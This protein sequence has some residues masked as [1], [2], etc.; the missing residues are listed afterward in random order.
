MVD[1]FFIDNEKKRLFVSSLGQGQ[2]VHLNYH[3]DIYGYG[4]FSA[5]LLQIVQIR[6]M[7]G[8]LHEHQFE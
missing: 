5:I 2:A 7:P 3:H 8:L 4:F 1:Y 6:Q